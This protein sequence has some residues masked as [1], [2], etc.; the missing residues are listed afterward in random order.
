MITRFEEL[1]DIV[2]C[3]VIAEDP[4]TL[5][6]LDE[7]EIDFSCISQHPEKDEFVTGV[8]V[9]QGKSALLRWMLDHAADHFLAPILKHLSKADLNETAQSM[10]PVVCTWVA[11]A[12][13]SELEPIQLLD[14]SVPDPHLKWFWLASRKRV[15]ELTARRAGGVHCS[16][17]RLDQPFHVLCVRQETSEQHTQASEEEEK[18]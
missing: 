10:R 13:L 12:K 4:S 15:S 14:Y 11:Q 7:A 18:L 1:P 6:V 16:F 17:A 3:L 8:A 2:T 5:S 9:E